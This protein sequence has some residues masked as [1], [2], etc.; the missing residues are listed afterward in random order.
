MPDE[1][2]GVITDADSDETTEKKDDAEGES[3]DTG[4]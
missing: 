4:M 2:D 1:D 3:E